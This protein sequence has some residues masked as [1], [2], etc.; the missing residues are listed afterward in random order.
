MVAA[1]GGMYLHKKFTNDVMLVKNMLHV[2]Q[3]GDIVVLY[4]EARY[5]LCGTNAVLPASLGKLVKRMNVPVV[6]LMMHGHH[7]NSPFWNT[8]NRAVKPIE[9]ELKLLYTPEQIRELT[10]NEINEGLNQAFE[11]D[12][13]RWQKE[14]EFILNIPTGLRVT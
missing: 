13:F 8:K 3:Q 7:V 6:T 4:P 11:Y 1:F 5:S 10:V 12:D 2:I 9:A 14:K